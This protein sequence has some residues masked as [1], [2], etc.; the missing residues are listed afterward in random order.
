MQE[1]KGDKEMQHDVTK[2]AKILMEAGM[3]EEEL[4]KA[5]E[6]KKWAE[7]DW[8][9]CN[10]GCEARIKRAAAEAAPKTAENFK[11]HFFKNFDGE[12]A[13][14]ARGTDF[15]AMGGCAPRAKVYRRSGEV[16]FVEVREMVDMT[17]DQIREY[18]VQ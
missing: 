11:P 10:R 8:T 18:T 17:S 5:F 6:A 9:V 2:E 13:I 15:A 7:E 16:T 12:W 4:Y 14:M 3:T 1:R